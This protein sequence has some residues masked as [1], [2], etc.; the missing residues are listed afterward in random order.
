MKIRYLT[1]ASVLIE[2]ENV[3]IL[4]DPWL[5]DGAYYGSWCHFPPYDFDPKLFD[6][7]DY[8]YLS[9]IHPDHA[10]PKTLGELNKKIPIFI[11]K[12]A[13]DYLKQN[14]TR[15]GFQVHELSHNTPEKLKKDL[16][17]NILAAD[18]CNPELCFKY[19]GCS[20]VEN[21]MGATS[22]DTMAVIDN[23]NEVI[24]NT[25]DCPFELAQTSASLVKKQ[26]DKIDMLLVG[27]TSASPFPQ[28][29][30]MP[31][32][33]KQLAQIQLKKTFVQ[34]AEQYVNLFK[35]K[36]FMPFAGRYTLAGKLSNLN[37]QKGVYELEEAYDYFSSS[38]NINHTETKCI[39]LNS[40]STFDISTSLSS[41]KYIRTDMGEKN[42]YVENILSKKKLDYEFEDIP[43]IEFFT[44]IIPK[45]YEKFE[46]KRKSMNFSSDTVVLIDLVDD[47]TAIISCNGNGFEILSNVNT[48]QFSKFVKMSVD[49]RLLAWLLKGPRFAVWNN[50]EIGSH[51]FYER[52]PEIYERPLFYCMSFFHS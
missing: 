48:S 30:E 26:Y 21:N 29:F 44:S 4:C 39:L 12:Y 19:F 18:N 46:Q 8:I 16:S 43:N 5:I 34:H 41:T 31:I 22:I 3:K 35:P 13:T 45:C 25:N 36:F 40:N 14:L 47:K 2:H 11:N 17:I 24:V 7:V 20:V 38:Q 49:P 50:A 51:I 1:S 9:H 6:D 42:Q 28:C 27:Y 52:N 23:G 37:S 15:L 10:H 32:K 33:Q